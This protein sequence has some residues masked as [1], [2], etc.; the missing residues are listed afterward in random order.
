M[1][2]DGTTIPFQKLTDEE[3]VQYRKEG[4]CFR[5]HQQGHM[6]SRCP[7]NA[8][9]P[10]NSNARETTTT[11]NSTTTTDTSTTNA[12]TSNV[13]IV[14]T[15]TTTATLTPPPITTPKL[16]RAQ[17]IRAIEEEMDEEE[18]GAYLDAWDMGEDFCVAGL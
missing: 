1:E 10:N 12:P 8:N 4:W 15:T 2:V 18:R 9:R 13:P 16:T 7:K 5:C 17:R 11:N 6:A 3:R 14:A